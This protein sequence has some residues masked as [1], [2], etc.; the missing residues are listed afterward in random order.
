M[1]STPSGLSLYGMTGSG[2]AQLQSTLSAASATPDSPIQPHHPITCSSKLYYEEDGTFCCE[3]ASVP[4]N[5]L[6]TRH[7]IVHSVALLI[8]ELAMLS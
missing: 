8:I 7:C 3:H 1:P 6:R 5:D 2:T 4:P